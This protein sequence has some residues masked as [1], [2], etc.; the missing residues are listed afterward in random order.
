MSME[1]KT[2]LSADSNIGIGTIK[3]LIIIRKDLDVGLERIME[4]S[5][6][7]MINEI[8]SNGNY[9][10]PPYISRHRSYLRFSGEDEELYRREDFHNWAL[11]AAEK[12]EYFFYVADIGNYKFEKIERP[13]YRRE[14]RIYLDRDIYD[15][16]FMTDQPREIRWARNMDHLMSIMDIAGKE[17]IDWRKYTIVCDGQY[18]VCVG[19]PP[20]KAYI[21]DSIASCFDK[22][23]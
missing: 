20:M 12:G 7:F 6:A 15:G 19:F 21:V 10:L 3:Q 22:E 9:C 11:E 2:Q 1:E 18:P 8:K 5:N 17:G 13:E 14:S 4:A 23:K 16:W